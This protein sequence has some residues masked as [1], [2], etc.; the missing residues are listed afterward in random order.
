M[1]N[2]QVRKGKI[3][4]LQLEVKQRENN[5]KRYKKRKIKR[6]NTRI[7]GHKGGTALLK[8]KSKK[9]KQHWIDFNVKR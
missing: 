9:G 2:Y 8:A 3:M 1:F 6:D 5:V 7:H 4:R